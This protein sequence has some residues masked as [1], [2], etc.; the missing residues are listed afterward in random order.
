MLVGVEGHSWSPRNVKH[1]QVG[2]IVQGG[3]TATFDGSE[4]MLEFRMIGDQ[5]PKDVPHS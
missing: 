3:D 5:F 1:R 2:G 4:R